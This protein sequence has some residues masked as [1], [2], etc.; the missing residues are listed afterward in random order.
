MEGPETDHDKDHE[1]GH[2]E[3]DRLIGSWLVTALNRDVWRK[4]LTIIKSIYTY[5]KPNYTYY[6]Y[7]LN[8][9]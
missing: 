2:D 8:N 7:I 5:H 4:G 3:L 9:Q 6:L 1:E